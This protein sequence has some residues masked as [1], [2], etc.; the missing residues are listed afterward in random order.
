MA[1]FFWGPHKENGYLSNWYPA[2]FY[3]PENGIHYQ[4]CEQYM[5]WRKAALFNDMETA[6]KIL[7]AETPKECK[8]LGHNLSNFNLQIWKDHRH[9][10]VGRGIFLKFSQNPALKERL[11]ATE[12]RILAEATPF[13]KIWGI[14]LNKH[15]AKHL[16][17]DQWI[18]QNLLGKLLMNLR[19]YFRE[20]EPQA[21][22]TSEQ[23]Q[24]TV[25]N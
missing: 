16:E 2:P 18:G 20:N 24:V 8:R 23:S 13:D 10:I 22:E 4:N 3:E 6:N 1:V 17:P 21:I 7:K 12:N 9:L 11:L 5:M 25:T 15:Q 14:G 19:Q